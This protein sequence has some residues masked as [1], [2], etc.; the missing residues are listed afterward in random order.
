[1]DRAAFVGKGQTFQIWEPE[2]LQRRKAEARIRTR[3]QKLT[4][5]L[6]RDDGGGS[7]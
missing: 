2:A 6:R 3:D 7:Q 4:L 5:R 1:L